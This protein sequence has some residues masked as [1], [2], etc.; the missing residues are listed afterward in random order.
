MYPNDFK[1]SVL[2]HG[3]PYSFKFGS[4]AYI[5]Q[6]GLYNDFFN[7][8]GANSLLQYVAFVHQCYIDDNNPTPLGALA[9][10]IAQNWETVRAKTSK[11]VLESFY[12]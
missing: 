5:F 8:Y 9:D 4:E 12:S 10:Y 1:V 7:H 11:E 2:F 6:T 3:H